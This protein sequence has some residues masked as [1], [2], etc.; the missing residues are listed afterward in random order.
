MGAPEKILRPPLPSV[1]NCRSREDDCMQGLGIGPSMLAQMC[2]G[3]KNL[4]LGNVLL[5]V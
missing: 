5:V 4:S 2:S 1:C 3:L